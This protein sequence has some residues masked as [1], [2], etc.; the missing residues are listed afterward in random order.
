MTIVFSC[1]LT[2]NEM[3][4]NEKH[5]CQTHCIC[6]LESGFIVVTGEANPARVLRG[7]TTTYKQETEPIRSHGRVWRHK[8]FDFRL[9]SFFF[10]TFSMIMMATRYRLTYGRSFQSAKSQR[11]PPFFSLLYPAVVQKPPPSYEY[12]NSFHIHLHKN[13]V[14]FFNLETQQQS[15]SHVLL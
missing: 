7:T 5:A 11:F 2:K 13:L 15:I 1:P 8:D 10:G 6:L 12:I 3:L 14:P 9:L 4:M